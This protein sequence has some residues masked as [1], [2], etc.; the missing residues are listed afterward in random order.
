MDDLQTLL[1]VLGGILFGVL[2]TVLAQAATALRTLT[3][4]LTETSRR[5]RD[6]VDTLQ[7][8]A[9]RVKRLTGLV[10]ES[11]PD[12]KRVQAALHSFSGAAL[13]ASD[14][15]DRITNVA[16]LVTPVVLTAARRWLGDEDGA[17]ADGTERKDRRTNNGAGASAG[18]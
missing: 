1:L 2:V 16:A 18:E 13:R 4:E 14:N 12:L 11:E 5:V 7:P 15:L 3:R 8:A 6:T 17:V 10:E 9:V